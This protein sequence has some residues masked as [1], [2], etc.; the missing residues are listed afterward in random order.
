M[1]KEDRH[2]ATLE[3]NQTEPPTP[4][5]QT[6]VARTKQIFNLVIQKLEL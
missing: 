4:L 5:H 6:T 1:R 2:K 3:T